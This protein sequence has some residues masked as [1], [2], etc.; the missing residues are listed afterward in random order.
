MVSV[1]GYLTEDV[2]AMR[3]FVADSSTTVKVSFTGISMDRPFFASRTATVAAG[4]HSPDELFD[5]YMDSQKHST[6]T[7][8][9]ASV[10][11]EVGGEFTAFH[12]RLRGRNLLIVPNRLI[13]QSWRASPW[14]ETDLDSVLILTFSE[15]PG[16]AQIDL[17][18]ANVPEHAYDIIHDGWPKYYW[19]PWRAYLEQK[20]E[21]G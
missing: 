18:H 20:S 14:K 9:E 19:G 6:A 10:S 1:V 7:K 13:A 4:G 11:R 2:R 16:G 3:V 15:A 8:A 21:Q 12:G 17:V 5:L